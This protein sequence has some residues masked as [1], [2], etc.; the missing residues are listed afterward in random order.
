MI[1]NM[2]DKWKKRQYGE[3]IYLDFKHLD[4]VTYDKSNGAVAVRIESTEQL[5][6]GS[7]TDLRTDTVTAIDYPFDSSKMIY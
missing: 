5:L 6:Q 1:V 7:K 3:T 2:E 4:F